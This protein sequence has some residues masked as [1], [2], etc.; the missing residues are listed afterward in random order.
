MEPRMVQDHVKKHV[1]DHYVLLARLYSL[2]QLVS[3]MHVLRNENQHRFFR[4]S[5]EFGQVRG[6]RK[7]FIDTGAQVGF[8]SG[9]SP[10][11]RCAIFI[12]PSHAAVLVPCGE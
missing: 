4:G 10:T 12:L 3:E 6:T 5:R 2:G 1:R 11:I 7:S 8:L 9:G